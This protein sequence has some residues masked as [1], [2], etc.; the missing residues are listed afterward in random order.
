MNDICVPYGFLHNKR[1][2]QVKFVFADVDRAA[3]ITMFGGG[4]VG[5]HQNLSLLGSG[6]NG[7]TSNFY[8]EHFGHQQHRHQVDDTGSLF[9]SSYPVSVT[10]EPQHIRLQSPPHRLNHRNR[11]LHHNQQ[12]ETGKSQLLILLQTI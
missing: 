6:G 11:N 5:G 9:S 2:S 1:N 3:S 10:S 7:N 12:F 8:T 4:V